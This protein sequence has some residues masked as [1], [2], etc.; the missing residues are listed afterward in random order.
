MQK[1]D[2]RAYAENRYSGL[3]LTLFQSN[4]NQR[5]I[6]NYHIYLEY[7]LYSVDV[8][9]TTEIHPTDFYYM[10]LDFFYIAITFKL[11]RR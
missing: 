4:F 10:L 5:C 11:Y 6:D 7:D 3:H 1:P 2:T 9:C 8:L